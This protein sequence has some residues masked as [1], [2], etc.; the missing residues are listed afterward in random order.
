MFS[1]MKSDKSADDADNAL[2]ER[3]ARLAGL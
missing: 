3:W 2:F 1:Q